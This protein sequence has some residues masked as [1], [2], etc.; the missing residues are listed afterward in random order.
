MCISKRNGR[1]AGRRRSKDMTTLPG[2]LAEALALAEGRNASLKSRLA[3]YRSE[4]S[5]LRPDIAKLF[6]QLVERLDR[7]D[8]GEVG[9]RVGEPMP[10]FALP[11]EEARLVTLSSLL[12]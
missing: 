10:E 11:D 4:S 9:P 2:S 1:Y 7:L 6:D 12:R 3:E 8:R 5:R